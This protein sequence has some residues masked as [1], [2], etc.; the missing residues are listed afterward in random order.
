LVGSLFG[1]CRRISSGLD[2]FS[3]IEAFLFADVEARQ[4][5]KWSGRWAMGDNNIRSGT[6]HLSDEEFVRAFESCELVGASFHHADHVRLTWIYVRQYGEQAAT[7]R[8]MA[9]I[10]RFATHSGSAQKF[11][12]TQTCAWVRLIAAAQRGRSELRTFVEFIAAHPELLDAN[13]LARY[14]SKSVLESP[15][16]RTG[17]VEPDVSPLPPL[18]K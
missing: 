10:R 3:W 11:H 15:A 6:L 12:Q 5:R 7:E 1:F 18:R 13:A 2:L 14:Y 4:R 9:G 17:W 16:A 8:V